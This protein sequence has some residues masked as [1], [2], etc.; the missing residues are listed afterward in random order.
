MFEL[1]VDSVTFT[2][3]SVL[4]TYVALCAN[5]LHKAVNGVL[6]TQFFL[7][8]FS[9]LN[10]NVLSNSCWATSFVNST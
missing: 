8:D 5:N 4:V 1:T 10:H 3:F 7:S 9:A 2:Y 6:I